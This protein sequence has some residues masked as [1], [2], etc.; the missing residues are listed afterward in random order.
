MI[1]LLLVLNG[2]LFAFITV[3]TGLIGLYGHKMYRKFF[4][5]LEGKQRAIETSLS[6]CKAE[7]AK[8]NALKDEVNEIKRQNQVTDVKKLTGRR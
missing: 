4:K 5:R 1:G 2:F 6:Y 7:V 3:T 8:L